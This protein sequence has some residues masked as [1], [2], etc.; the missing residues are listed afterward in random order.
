MIIKCL[1]IYSGNFSSVLAFRWFSYGTGKADSCPRQQPGTVKQL[2]P[3]CLLFL[4]QSSEK[5]TGSAS[6]NMLKILQTDEGSHN[7]PPYRMPFPSIGRGLRPLERG[8]ESEFE[9]KFHA[10]NTGASTER[11]HSAALAGL[12]RSRGH[13]S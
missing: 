7:S 6:N 11:G 8:N 10:A 13:L 2:L 9:R 12:S 1:D 4:Y 3:S 5:Q